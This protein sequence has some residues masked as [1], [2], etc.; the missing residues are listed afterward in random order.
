MGRAFCEVLNE[1]MVFKIYEVGAR[2]DFVII[3]YP[4]K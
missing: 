4:L 3:S 1:F 2:H